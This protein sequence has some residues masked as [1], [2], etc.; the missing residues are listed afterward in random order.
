MEVKRRVP[1]VLIDDTHLSLASFRVILPTINDE[2]LEEK[3]QVVLSTMLK[4]DTRVQ[5]EPDGLA[6]I[7]VDEVSPDDIGAHFPQD[8][9]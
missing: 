9:E 6:G 1:L 7:E 5:S 2:A 4:A 3:L 8:N